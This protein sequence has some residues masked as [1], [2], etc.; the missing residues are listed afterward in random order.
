MTSE[1]TQADRELLA[2]EYGEGMASLIREGT[3][4]SRYKP[5]LRAI[6]KLRSQLEAVTAQNADSLNCLE[7]LLEA[8]RIGIAD[9]KGRY[10]KAQADVSRLTDLL[11]RAGDFTGQF[12]DRAIQRPDYDGERM[13]YRYSL[14]R[15]PFANCMI[16]DVK[17]LHAEI[18]AT[19]EG[20]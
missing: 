12:V 8:N 7:E 4:D 19:L 20:K 10:D 15:H 13:G 11:R 9:W 1:V 18:T 2:A 3:Y 5:V 6:S 14:A 17:A 16:D